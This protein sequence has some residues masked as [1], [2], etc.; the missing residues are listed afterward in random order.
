MKRKFYEQLDVKVENKKSN[1]SFLNIEKYELLK[2]LQL[3][4]NTEPLS[5]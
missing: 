2:W 4:S 5:S 1:N 3:E